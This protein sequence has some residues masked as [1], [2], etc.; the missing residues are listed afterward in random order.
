MCILMNWMHAEIFFER[1]F[2][3]CT[4]KSFSTVS[5]WSYC[6]SQIAKL[7]NIFRCRQILIVESWL[8][9]S[10]TFGGLRKWYVFC[11]ISEHC[12]VINAAALWFH[13]TL[14]NGIFYASDE[15]ICHHVFLKNNNWKIRKRLKG[16]EVSLFL[17]EERC[18]FF[19]M[20]LF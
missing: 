9:I 4:G 13:C 10:Y 11:V 6:W 15:I 19:P 8:L 2:F 5:F 3:D 7:L 16:K 18:S 17:P 14:S 20:Q 1:L 12:G